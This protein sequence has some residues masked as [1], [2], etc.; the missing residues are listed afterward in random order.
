MKANAQFISSLK[1]IAVADSLLDRLPQ[2]VDA[3]PSWLT[4]EA[5][6]WN[7]AL[8]HPLVRVRTCTLDFTTIKHSELRQLARVF[9]LWRIVERKNGPSALLAGLRAFRDIGTALEARPMSTL[10]V[11]DFYAAELLI[12]KMCGQGTFARRCSDLQYVAEWLTRHA[13]IRVGYTSKHRAERTH[14]R[15]ATDDQ[16]DAKLLLD[17]VVSDLLSA[18]L[19]EDISDRDRFFLSVTAIATA[20]G[21]RLMELLTLPIDCLIQDQGVLLVRSFVSKNGKAAP[22]PVPPE[23]ADIVT[24]AVAYLKSVTEPARLQAALLTENSPISWAEILRASDLKPLEYFV[25]RWLAERIANPENRMIDTRLAYFS[26]GRKSRWVPIAYLLDKHD[27]NVS[28]ISRETGYKRD[29]VNRLISQLNASQRNEVYLGNKNVEAKRGFD[30]DSRSPSLSALSTHIGINV[31]NS[32]CAPLLSKLIDEARVSQIEQRS[33]YAPRR[34]KKLEARFHFKPEVLRN[35]ESG[36][37]VLELHNALFITFKNQLSDSH[38]SDIER[39]V[40]VSTKQFSDWLSGYG[41]DRGTGKAGDA[42]CARLDI[43]DPRSGEPARFTNHDFR[44]WLETA[45]ENGGLSQTQIATL[46]N[47]QSPATNSVYDQTNSKVRRARLQNAMVDG[48]LIGHAAQAFERIATESPK[49]AAEYLE[50]ATKFYNPMPHGI[51]RL[52]WALEP[53]PH[54]LSCFSCEGESFDEPTPCEYLIVDTEN[55]A[56]LEEIDLVH[57]NATAIKN[58]MEDEGGESSPQFERFD[59]I[60]RSTAKLLKNAGKR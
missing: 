19:R 17:S 57:R 59:R 27:G 41:R 13:G 39:V 12:R 5:E 43:L 32:P 1:D 47:R 53:C 28:A 4:P 7:V 3:A 56:Q 45:Y 29:T 8:L 26:Q 24:D 25:R 51:C 35:P 16:R 55:N 9:T 60:A 30:T 58:L 49:E 33:F 36:E 37:T 34:D 40:A 52:N 48:L 54:T 10:K 18:R 23:L 2:L 11:D 22:R 31:N 21:F 15:E 6:T 44:H 46:F 50:T 38:R 42:V 14:G 20:T